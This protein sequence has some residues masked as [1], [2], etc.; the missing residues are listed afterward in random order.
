MF[1]AGVIVGF[2]A[3]VAAKAFRNSTNDWGARWGFFLGLAA[4]L[5]VFAALLLG[6]NNLGYIIQSPPAPSSSLE[7]WAIGWAIYALGWG[8]FWVL[9]MYDALSRNVVFWSDISGILAA[10]GALILQ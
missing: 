3:F 6:A 4:P 7:R 9:G 5:I 10:F 2:G 1:V 8:L